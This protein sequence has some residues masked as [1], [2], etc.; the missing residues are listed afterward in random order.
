[1][2]GQEPDARPHR[3]AAVVVHHRAYPGVLGTV[4]ALLAQ[5]LD[6]DDVTVVDNS[7]D[8]GVAAALRAELPRGVTLLVVPN[9]GYAASANLGVEHALASTRPRPSE[10]LVSTHETRP[11]P[12][13]LAGLCAALDSDPTLGVVG[14]ALSNAEQSRTRAWSTGGIR[15]GLTRRAKHAGHGTP[16][17]E[18]GSPLTVIE[19]DWLDGSFCLYRVEAIEARRLEESYFLYFEEV[20][21]HWSL[22]RDGWRVGCVTSVWVEQSSHGM[23]PFY[24]GRNLRLIQRRHGT[25]RS[26]LLAAPEAL[27]LVGREV[28][29]GHR[30]WWHVRDFLQG[31]FA[32][33]GGVARTRR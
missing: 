14:P 4:E 22:Q 1:M 31:W 12:G 26:R 25:T 16:L 27:L 33:H 20:D 17:P 7:E 19:R 5:G 32:W 6:V 10:I 15:T 8:D 18:P 9:D 30:P 29:L 13:A 23:P 28:I 24:Y 2:A 11:G 3:T 21:M